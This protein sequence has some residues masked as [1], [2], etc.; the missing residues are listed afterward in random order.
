MLIIKNNNND[1]NNDDYVTNEVE[2]YTANNKFNST[3]FVYLQQAINVF[4][5]RPIRKCN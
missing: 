5:A 4:S 1:D 3:L 2:R